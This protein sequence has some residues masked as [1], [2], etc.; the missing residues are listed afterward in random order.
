MALNAAIEAARAGDAG[1]G[2][3]VVAEQVRKLAEDSK[4]AANQINGLISEIKNEVNIAVSETGTTA[5]AIN[6]GKVALDETALQLENLFSI[7]KMT[8][9]GINIVI[10]NID[11]QDSDISQIVQEVEQ[12][13]GIIEQSSGNAQE[14]SSSIEEMAATLEELSAAAEE[15]NAGSS[16]L[17]GE[18]QNF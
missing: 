14:L 12:I 8:D 4:Q 3:A 7:I 16:R 10:K 17:F 9:Q 11:E 13:N 5:S 18:I 15:L 1:K 2:F 6:N